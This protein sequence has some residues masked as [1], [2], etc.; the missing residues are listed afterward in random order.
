LRFGDKKGSENVVADHL[1]RITVDFTEEATPIS[2]TFPDEQLMYIAYTPSPWFADIVNY[3]VTGQMPLHWGRQ[4][5][6]KFMAMVK[7][8]F[9]DDPYLFKYCLDQIIRRC[10]P[11]LDQ[12]NVISFV[13][14]MLVKSISMQIRLLQRFCSVDFIGRPFS[15]TLTII[16]SRVSAVRS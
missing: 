7:Y 3:L 12:P 9:W 11:E 1:S 10:I 6:S 5:K 2:E 4:D 16:V 15:K 8:F 14:I 13:M